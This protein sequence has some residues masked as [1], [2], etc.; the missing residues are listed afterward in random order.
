MRRP[1]TIHVITAVS[2]HVSRMS[3]LETIPRSLAGSA[4][5]L[6]DLPPNCRWEGGGPP[7]TRLN[8]APSIC[9]P[10]RCQPGSPAGLGTVPAVNQPQLLSE[11][12]TGALAPGMSRRPR[13]RWKSSV[14]SAVAPPRPVQ[15]NAP[16]PIANGTKR[17]PDEAFNRD[18]GDESTFIAERTTEPTDPIPDRRATRRSGGP[19]RRW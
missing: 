10:G 5:V 16:S 15:A 2:L 9:Q 8:A 13:P 3:I 14:A 18:N 12:Q 4:S 17:R 6:A 19:R 7:P 1:G 11:G